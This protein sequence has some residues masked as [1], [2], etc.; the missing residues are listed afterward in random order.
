MRLWNKAAT[1]PGHRVPSDY[2]GVYTGLRRAGTRGH[3]R[4]M[5][6]EASS[7][8][9]TRLGVNDAELLSALASRTYFEH[10]PDLWVDGG[11][12]YVREAYA[13]TRLRAELAE[14]TVLYC[15]IRDEHDEP[16]GFIKLVTPSPLELPP[17][18]GRRALYLERLYLLPDVT[19]RGFGSAA[20][21]WIHEH[22][23]ENAC[24]IVWL[25]VMAC[26]PTVRAFY[27]RHGYVVCGRDT[28]DRPLVLPDRAE[29]FVMWRPLS[30]PT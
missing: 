30:P 1:L 24:E 26:R 10:Y 13:V 4:P 14:P 8:H 6:S 17:C 19:G 25:R 11:A 12:S 7:M 29:M 28:L 9:V 3:T 20:M 2:G 22:G 21:R 16:V 27:E 5:A 18:S 15:S 23:A